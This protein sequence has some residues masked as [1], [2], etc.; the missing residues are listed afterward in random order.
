MKTENAKAAICAACTLALAGLSASPSADSFA[1]VTNDWYNGCYSNVMEL[2]DCRLQV[3]TNDLVG[4]YLKAEYAISFQSLDDMSNAVSRLIE[5]CD[6]P[7]AGAYTNVFCQSKE[8]WEHYL[9][10]LIPSW[11]AEDVAAQHAESA[12]PHRK[13]CLERSLRIISEMGLWETGNGSN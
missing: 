5:V 2:A 12:L 1:S 9:G 4:T 11:T 3:N 10:V 6:S 8:G 13:M 7:Y